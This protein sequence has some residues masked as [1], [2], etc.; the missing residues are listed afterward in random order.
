MSQKVNKK[1][2]KDGNFQRQEH[3]SK[4]RKGIPRWIVQLNHQ[5]TRIDCHLVGSYVKKMPLFG[6]LFFLVKMQIISKM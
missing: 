4:S 3:F 1:R 6:W 2:Q 5:R